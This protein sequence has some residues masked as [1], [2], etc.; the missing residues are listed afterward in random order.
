M[1]LG[2]NTFTQDSAG[3]QAGPAEDREKPLSWQDCHRTT[4]LSYHPS[5]CTLFQNPLL[6]QRSLRCAYLVSAGASLRSPSCPASRRLWPFPV[7]FARTRK[8]AASNVLLL[9]SIHFETGVTAVFLLGMLVCGAILRSCLPFLGLTPRTF[10]HSLK[11]ASSVAGLHGVLA[12]SDLCGLK[13][14]G[15]RRQMCPLASS[16]G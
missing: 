9:K 12:T 6:G 5:K 15:E 2:Q 16:F 13:H 7:L 8:G 1:D 11:R 3:D 14:V 4:A 10:L